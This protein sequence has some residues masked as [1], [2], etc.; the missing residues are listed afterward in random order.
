MQTVFNPIMKMFLEKKGKL[1]QEIWPVVQNDN[2]PARIIWGV[3]DTEKGKKGY[4][5]TVDDWRQKQCRYLIETGFME[6]SWVN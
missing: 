1:P 2:W 6:Y 4:W 5:K 3:E